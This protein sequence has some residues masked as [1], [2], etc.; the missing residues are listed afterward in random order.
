MSHADSRPATTDDARAELARLVTAGLIFI[1]YFCLVEAAVGWRELLRQ[2]AAAGALP[3]AL[4]AGG[5]GGSY[6]LRALRLVQV[7]APAAVGAAATPARPAPPE[8][9]PGFLC[10]LRCL[11]LN[12]AANWLLPA[13]AGDLGL[14]LL[15]HR[16]AGLPK[17]R[18]VGVLLWLR[19]LDLQALAGIGGLT[20]ALT[21]DGVARLGGLAAL[22]GSAVA[23]LV[24]ARAAPLLSARVPRLAPALE[25][26]HRPAGAFA[27]DIGLTWLAWGVKLVALGAVLAL[28]GA[29]PF[30]AGL[31]GAIGG[32]LST[33]LPVHAPLGA[34]SF[35]SGVLLAMTPWGLPAAG[36][37]AAAVQLHLLML[38]VALA[39]TGA[40]LL[41]PSRIPSQ[42][43][44]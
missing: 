16:E 17:A 1:V 37:L 7:L 2:F 32:D 20:F 3:L 44:P 25:L 21:A 24:I 8:A 29:L 23:P 18:G 31:A 34:G 26:L 10:L 33:V 12:N 42:E 36:L 27:R 4:A 41:I 40:S 38:A 43:R 6:A 35:E 19:L 28:V 14:P 5:L 30:G 13:R 11:L 39:A 9:A 22:A 15:L